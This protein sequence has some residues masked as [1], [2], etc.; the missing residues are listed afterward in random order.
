MHR[1]WALHWASARLHT[2]VFF[3]YF[4]MV[5]VIEAIN[6]G[7]A[8]IKTLIKFLA[9][10][11]LFCFVLFWRHWVIKQNNLVTG[12]SQSLPPLLSS[13]CHILYIND[14]SKLPSSWPRVC[15]CPAQL[16]VAHW[17]WNLHIS[18]FSLTKPTTFF[19]RYRAIY[20][21][22]VAKVYAVFPFYDVKCLCDF[23]GVKTLWFEFGND[24]FNSF[25]SF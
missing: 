13:P 16:L 18:S 12:G 22:S 24:I 11:F 8:F 15:A 20:L 25:K 7:G 14:T 1:K 5:V 17:F 9:S 21:H 19:S 6:R 2:W 23:Y 3:L 4:F 10:I